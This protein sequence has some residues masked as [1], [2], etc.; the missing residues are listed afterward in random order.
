MIRTKLHTLGLFPPVS[1]EPVKGCVRKS[2]GKGRGPGEGEGHLEGV[3]REKEVGTKG[4]VIASKGG[5][6]K[7]RTPA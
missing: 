6:E 2:E 4:G 5:G 7:Q 1:G 3:E